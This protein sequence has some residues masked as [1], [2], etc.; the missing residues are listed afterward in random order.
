VPAAP[1]PAAPDPV[2]SPPSANAPASVAAPASTAAPSP[3]TLAADAELKTASGTTYPVAA[4]WT[5]TRHPGAAGPHEL[6]ELTDP[7]GTM[8]LYLDE[9]TGRTPGEAI[10]ETWQRVRPGFALAAKNTI[11]PPA[12]M[13]DAVEQTVYETGDTKPPRLAIGL[14]RRKGDRVW[15]LLVDAEA[16]ALDRRGAQL[17]NLVDHTRAPGVEE[18]SFAGRTP[19]P[20]EGERAAAFVDF[21]EKTRAALNVPGAAVAVV[22]NGRV[23]LARG[24]GVRRLGA[25]GPTDTVTEKTPFLIGS[26]T[27]G[28]TTA[29]M[30]VAVDRGLF[31]WDT[32][33]RKLHPGFTLGD[34]ALAARLTMRDLVC[35]C[36]GLPRSDMELL[37]EFRGVKPADML[38]SLARQK[39]TTAFGETF[40]YNNQ[41]VAAAGFVTARAL[42]PKLEFGAGYDRALREHILRPLGMAK[43]TTDLVAARRAGLAASHGEDVTGALHALPDDVE[44]FLLPLRPSG[45]VAASVLDMAGYLQTELARGQ[46]P[47]GKR[48]ATEAAWLKRREPQVKIGEEESYGLGLGVGRT[49]GVPYVQHTGGTFGQFTTFFVLPEAGVGLVVLT[50]GPG[51]LGGLARTRLLELLYDGHPRAAGL[52]AFRDAERAK[53]LARAAE[54]RAENEPPEV[55]AALAGEYTNDRLGRLVLRVENGELTA[56]V[57]EWRTRLGWQ[58]RA[59]GGKDLL[60]LDP[61]AAGLTLER[62]PGA[63]GR[64]KLTLTFGQHV[65]VFAQR[66]D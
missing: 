1:G 30:A 34:E 38:A 58:K 40:Q 33:V 60:V 46:G 4:G 25:T 26:V 50:N 23:V 48:V 13:W 14:G 51:G 66:A 62:A 31:T 3:T 54:E 35:A 10:A 9:V 55:L 27:K 61:P 39:P 7:E 41:L 20:L 11:T 59:D 53:S 43:A 32:P 65:H 44:D 24:F 49:R 8:H 17:Q 37:F 2:A 19:H 52:L 45:G 64:P 36:T 57:G 28:L 6:I 16:A 22:Q 63:D 12:Q 42:Y 21:V 18:E 29:L 56:D 15:V 47:D 5:I